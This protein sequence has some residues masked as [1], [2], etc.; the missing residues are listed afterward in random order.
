LNSGSVNQGLIQ[1]P[2][3]FITDEAFANSS[4][5]WVPAGAL[6][7]ALAGQGKTKGM[8]AQLAFDATCN[9]SM[10]AIVPGHELA[11][12]YLL[13]WL[14]ANYQNI[15]N[16]SGGDN[17]D[18]LNLELLGDILCPLP[19][20]REQ[21]TIAAFLDRETAKIDALMEEQ[22][23]LI[24]LLK[25]KRQAV[26]SHAVTKGLDPTMPMKHSGVE[27]LGEVPAH[28]EINRLDRLMSF[29]SGKAHEP[30]LADDG[31]HI[32]ISARFVSTHGQSLKFCT[33]NLAPAKRGDVVMVMS[34]LPNGRALARAYQIADD[35]S[36]AVNQ[37]VCRLKGFR[38]S[39]RYFY[40][41]LNRNPGLRRYDDG[42]NQTHL[43]NSAY[44]KLPLCAPP[45]PEQSQIAEYLDEQTGRIDALEV[46][47]AAAISVLQERRVA[48]ISAA[49]SGKI[50]VR[51]ASAKQ[52]KAA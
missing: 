47:A 43:S 7:M 45:E 44:C 4:T 6:L 11:S 5:R 10:A 16:M 39:A 20:I 13:W 50:D 24:E 52:A 46:A 41:Q 22:Q 36:Y 35:A 12:R 14:S 48:L 2:S 27:W 26:V 3:A 51:N 15:R 21:T 42:V 49:V 30:F 31:E 8:T 38:G 40:Y 9:Q 19:P 34:D 25:V 28:W 18:G 29:S 37:R 33:E 23:R 17:R 32:Y 1:E